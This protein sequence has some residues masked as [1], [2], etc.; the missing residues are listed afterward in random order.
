MS[1]TSF[2]FF[3]ALVW[4]LIHGLSHVSKRSRQ[5]LP[6]YPDAVR[7]RAAFWNMKHCRATVSLLHLRITTSA[8]NAYHDLLADKFAGKRYPRLTTF[9]RLFYNLG[10]VMG[11]LGMCGALA[12]LAWMT[13]C[14]VWSVARKLLASSVDNASLESH[15]LSR[16]GLPEGGSNLHRTSSSYPVIAPIVRCFMYRS[17]FD[18]SD[19]HLE[20]RY[21]V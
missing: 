19:L 16:R 3:L 18:L 20:C 1:F 15:I 2:V 14:S 10:G 17:H 5:L 9:S 12:A 8:F 11:V 21:Q 6:L 13:G 4:S 7:R